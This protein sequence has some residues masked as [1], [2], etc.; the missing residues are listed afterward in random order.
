[1][2]ADYRLG[3]WI[4]RTQRRLVERGNESIHVTRGHHVSTAVLHD[5]LCK[6]GRRRCHH[7]K[8]TASRHRAQCLARRTGDCR[9]LPKCHE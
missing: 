8:R 2:S 7:E 9:L 1:M 4:V 5:H 3:E 6:V